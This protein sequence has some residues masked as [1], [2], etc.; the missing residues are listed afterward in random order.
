[1]NFKGKLLDENH[2]KG[3]KASPDHHHQNVA[4]P[5]ALEHREKAPPIFL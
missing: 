4:S 5:F 1:M 2:E 3:T